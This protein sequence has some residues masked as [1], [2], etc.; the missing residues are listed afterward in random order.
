MNPRYGFETLAIHAGQDP[1]ATT[2]A[3]TTP[4]F[5]TST[6]AQEGLGK[7]FQGK[8]E[9]SRTE[10][11]TRG[12]LEE[13][14]A[15][16]EGGSHGLAFSSG[17][18]ATANLMNLLKAGDHM[19]CGDDVY[20]G[21]YRLFVRV[22]EKFGI[23]TEFVDL[24]DAAALERHR[25]PNTRMLW[26]ETPTNPLLKLADLEACAGFAKRHN[27]IS[28]VD[29]TFMTPYFQRPLE[30][31]ID[32]VVH[33]ATKYLGGHSDV[34]NGV[35]VT[36]SKE[37]YDNQKFHQNAVGAVPGPLDAWLVLRGL[38]TL[39]VRMQRH[40][41]NA[42]ALAAMLAEHEAVESVY[43]PGLPAHPQHAL[44]K[45]QMRGFGGMISFVIRGGLEAARAFMERLRLF[46]LAESLGGVESLA[47]HPAI[48]T[49]ASIPAAR[50][51]EL[52]I[53]DGLIRL[54]VGIET[55]DDLAND[56]EQA[57]EAAAK[58]LH[59]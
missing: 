55:Q 57:F 1:E 6:Y 27:I 33:S 37:I 24:S 11:P 4:I 56:L 15:A 50:R 22:M 40:E 26:I 17:M 13:C 16:L 10:N 20:G 54:S 47:D 3:V 29:N 49:H 8:Y 19:L 46:T 25:R 34:V 42:R 32:V 52:G 35:L 18:A 44:A 14:I 51:A 9:Y 53:S 2:G 7:P 38:K 43:Y 12:A 5:Q 59:A 58:G 30:Y 39:A 48:M 21:T 31:G 23:Q 45:K 36:S 28:V 41:E